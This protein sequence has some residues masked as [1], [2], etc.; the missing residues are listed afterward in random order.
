LSEALIRSL[1]ILAVP[2]SVVRPPLWPLSIWPFLYKA[3]IDVKIFA[4]HP[5]CRKPLLEASPDGT[6]REPR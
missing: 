6:A 4:R 1:A 2:A 5:S 3:A